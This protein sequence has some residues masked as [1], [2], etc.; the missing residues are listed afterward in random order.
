[1]SDILR[2]CQSCAMPIKEGEELWG[3][4]ADGSFSEDYCSHCYRDGEFVFPAAMEDMI[5][6]YVP[7]MLFSN[8]GLTADEARA[9]MLEYFPL[10]KR[11]ARKADPQPEEVGQTTEAFA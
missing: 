9:R 4:E 3:T 2:Y 7:D 6:F 11:W 1:M 8:P 10:L 5:E